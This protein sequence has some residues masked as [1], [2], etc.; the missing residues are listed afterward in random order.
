[1][2]SL[3]I[4][5]TAA[6][7]VVICFVILYIVFLGRKRT[8]ISSVDR[9]DAARVDA[10]LEVKF[11]EVEFTGGGSNLLE[12]EFTSNVRGLI[13]VLEYSEEGDQGQLEVKEKPP[14]W[15]AGWLGKT[16]GILRFGGS[17][18]LKLTVDLGKG[19][20]DFKLGG[21][22]VE[23]LQVKATAG[24]VNV[25]AAGEMSLLEKVVIS[26]SAGDIGL[27]MDGRY[28]AMKTLEVKNSAGN[29]SM[30][31][32]GRWYRDLECTVTSTAGEIQIGVPSDVGVS[33]EVKSTVGDVKAKGMT[34]MPDG[35]YANS[36]LGKSDVT[37][38]LSVKSTAGEVRLIPAQG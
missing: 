12:A 9:G 8:S 35:I 38:R 36:V 34:Q 21:V 30:S 2:G 10:R 3:T 24:R 18:P 32:L 20:G 19:D 25:E 37:L 17:I 28:P 1:M 26:Q 6:A 14:S 13:P 29:T 22:S 33:I 4:A 31:L 16:R 27:A 23:E 15:F 7:A 11:A 5:I